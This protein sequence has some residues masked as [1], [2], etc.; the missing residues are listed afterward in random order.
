MN[1]DDAYAT[2]EET[3]ATL[4]VYDLEPAQV[5]TTLGIEPTSKQLVGDPINRAGRAAT[6]HGWFFTTRGKTSSRDSR[7]HLDE[8]LSLLE[9]KRDSI[10]KL[11]AMGCQI[12]LVCYWRSSQGHGGPTLSPQQCLALGHAGVDLWYDFYAE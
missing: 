4:R 10:E 8:V 6:R 9:G 3:Y 1:Y 2:C 5:S 7:R 11:R 12:D